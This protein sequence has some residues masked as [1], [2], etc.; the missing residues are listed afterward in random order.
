[1]SFEAENQPHESNQYNHESNMDNQEV[2]LETPKESNSEKSKSHH[3]QSLNTPT[4]DNLK[5]EEIR[6]EIMESLKQSATKSN[7]QDSNPNV[8]PI[9]TEEPTQ[10][11]HIHSARSMKSIGQGNG[12]SPRT[13]QLLSVLERKDLLTPNQ[14]TENQNGSENNENLGG[15]GEPSTNHSR[16]NLPSTI[17]FNT[18]RRDNIFNQP[19]PIPIQATTETYNYNQFYEPHTEEICENI[20]SEE[21]SLEQENYIVET[22]HYGALGFNLNVDHNKDIEFEGYGSVRIR[23]RSP[24]GNSKSTKKGEFNQVTSIS[25]TRTRTLRQHVRVSHASKEFSPLGGKNRYKTTGKKGR[26][27][28]SS[29]KNM[30][31]RGGRNVGLTSS[32]KR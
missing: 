18:T 29:R 1:M 16:K 30:N 5:P 24:V 14:P 32:N 23:S 21:Y 6:R 10:N 25:R 15:D 3:S 13:S 28:L 12:F 22:E 9:S 4:K 17:D 31:A 7:A 2:L 27:S 20:P 26:N 11:K 19:P 8:T